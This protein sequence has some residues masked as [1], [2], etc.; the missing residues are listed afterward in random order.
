MQKGGSIFSVLDKYCPKGP[1]GIKKVDPAVFRGPLRRSRRGRRGKG[2]I[3]DMIKKIK[4][5][6]KRGG[7]L[8]TPH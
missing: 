2:L 6:V 5:T 4:Q 8:W 1:I 7:T 3:S